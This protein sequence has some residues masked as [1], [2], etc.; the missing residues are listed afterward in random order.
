M[1]SNSISITVLHFNKLFGQMF[2]WLQLINIQQILSIKFK[3]FQVLEVRAKRRK[4]LC[5]ALESRN[6]DMVIERKTTRR[7]KVQLCIFVWIFHFEWL[8]KKNEKQWCDLYLT[9]RKEFFLFI[10]T[11][12]L[13]EI[14]GKKWT[15]QKVALRLFSRQGWGKEED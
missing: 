2:Y 4:W 8:E 10:Y 15:G 5:D 13:I 9:K 1:A 3:L 12:K 14:G 11:I 6:S 7:G